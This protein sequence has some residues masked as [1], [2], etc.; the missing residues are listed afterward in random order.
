M[1]FPLIGARDYI[2]QRGFYVHECPH[3]KAPSLFAVYETKRKM[4]L[5]FVPTVT[6]RSQYVMECMTCH[7]RWGVPKDQVESLLANLMTQEEIAERTR[8]AQRR[9]QMLA[10]GAL[11]GMMPGAM[12]NQQPTLYEVLQVHHSADPDVIEAAFKRLALKYHPDRS[13]DPEAPAR[14]REILAAREVL[15]DERKRAAY[16]RSLGIVRRTRPIRVEALRADEV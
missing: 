7:N 3:C 10:N 8:E 11:P 15:T 4:T 14:M 9:A 6:A 16:D 1:V 5:Y 12:P 2:D 13:K